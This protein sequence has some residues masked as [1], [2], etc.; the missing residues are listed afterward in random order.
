M[1]RRPRIQFAAAVG[2]CTIVFI[3]SAAHLLA[4]TVQQ[5]ATPPSALE[6]GETPPTQSLA[7]DFNAQKQL[8][9]ATGSSSAA[10]L[11]SPVSKVTPGAVPPPNDIGN[12]VA[13][14]PGASTRGMQYFN[15]LNCVGCHAA[16]G[17]GGMG[18]ALSNRYFQYGDSPAQ[19][20][21]TIT[22]GRPNG[23]PAWGDVLPESTIW[24]L[25]A[26][27]QSLAEPAGKNFGRTVSRAPPSPD[28]QQTPQEYVQ[29]THPWSFTEPF[30][31]GQQPSGQ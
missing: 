16:N 17:G 21:L 5:P 14:D 6:G 8:E 4:Q 3:A 13:D 25:V 7:N 19:I 22:Q 29:T 18:P 11:K 9:A 23:M 28:I 2:A 20:Y 26:Y 12:P 15:T 1:T 31:N 27:V 10:L 24:E 30:S